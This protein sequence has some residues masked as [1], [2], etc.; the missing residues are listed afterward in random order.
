M[1]KNKNFTLKAGIMVF[2]FFL[3]GISGVSIASAAG[4][5]GM[6]RNESRLDVYT[7]T[8][9][10]YDGEISEQPAPEN[11][12]EQE[13]AERMNRFGNRFYYERLTENEKQLYDAFVQSADELLLTDKNLEDQES[14]LLSPVN[15]EGYGLTQEDAA[16]V[17]WLFY[18]ENPQYYFIKNSVSY[19]ETDISI[20]C[21]PDYAT[22]DERRIITNEVAEKMEQMINEIDKCVKKTEQEDYDILKCIHDEVCKNIRYEAYD[23]VYDQTI[24]MPLIIDGTGV[25][26]AYAKLFNMFCSYYEYECYIIGSENH[27]WNCVSVEDSWYYVDCTWDD[28]DD[29]NVCSYTFFLTSQNRFDN[30][31]Y[32]D[33]I[34]SH[35]PDDLFS[36]YCTEIHWRAYK[37]PLKVTITCK[38][39]KKTKNTVVTVKG[40]EGTSIRISYNNKKLRLKDYDPV[41][42]TS[43]NVLKI[44]VGW[45]CKINAVAYDGRGYASSPKSKNIK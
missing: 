24:V 40:T 9:T 39:N 41:Y 21:Y 25:C 30:Y 36:P 34:E 2:L 45:K 8:H 13:K 7:Q 38:K 29:E 44:T 18:Y 6:Y 5:N 22:G 23:G 31:P 3:C 35:S 16:K 42:Y 12:E 1:K 19:N 10:M 33:G 4:K 17:V 14:F 43:S 20:A 32:D 37:R 28:T 27:A 11:T 15:Y 26:T